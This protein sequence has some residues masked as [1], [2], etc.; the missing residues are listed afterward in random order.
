MGWQ[1]ACGQGND[2]GVI[3]RQNDIDPNDLHQADPKLGRL[4]H[5]HSDSCVMCFLWGLPVGDPSGAQSVT[6]LQLQGRW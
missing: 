2:H 3:A 5:F 4:Q 6:A 1:A